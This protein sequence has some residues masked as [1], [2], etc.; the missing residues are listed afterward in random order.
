VRESGHLLGYG[1][2]DTRM[3][4]SEC[5]DG[6]SGAEVEDSVA[7]H[8]MENCSLCAVDVER[9]ARSDSRSNR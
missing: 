1:I 7:V 2:N 8:I 6:D 5:R 9:K 3:R 4:V